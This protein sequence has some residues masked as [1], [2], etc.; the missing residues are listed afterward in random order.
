MF[1]VRLVVGLEFVRFISNVANS[2]CRR[3]SDKDSGAMVKSGISANARGAS[4]IA[5]KVN[6]NNDFI[7]CNI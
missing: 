5:S 6:K 7:F 3:F 1:N 4:D 2:F